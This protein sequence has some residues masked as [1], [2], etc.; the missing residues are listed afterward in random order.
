MP[1]LTLTTAHEQPDD[2]RYFRDEF[3]G[4]QWVALHPGL[5][6]R[7]RANGALAVFRPG[8]GGMVLP[9]DQ[10]R[11]L[12]RRRRPIPWPKGTDSGPLNN[13]EDLP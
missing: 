1:R 7:R 11:P 2:L 12:D 4:P 10:W 3:P 5:W 8:E 13:D 9:G 6:Q